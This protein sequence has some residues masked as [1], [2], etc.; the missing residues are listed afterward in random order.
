M[1]RRS[2]IFILCFALMA[3]LWAVSTAA[4][5]AAQHGYAPE[6]ELPSGEREAA[7]GFGLEIETVLGGRLV[8]RQDY[9]AGSGALSSSSRWSFREVPISHGR[10]YPVVGLDF[11]AG[12]AF[13]GSFDVEPEDAVSRRLADYLEEAWDGSEYF[14]TEI[15]LSDFAERY[16]P[17]ISFGNITDRDGRGIRSPY[18]DK[19]SV[20]V[21]EGSYYRAVVFGGGEWYISPHSGSGRCSAASSSVFTPEGSLFFTADVT[22]SAGERADGSSLPGGGW[23]VWRIPCEAEDAEKLAGVDRWWLTESFHAVCDET[24]LE[25]VFLLPEG[26]GDFEILLS[27]DG[28]RLFVISAEGGALALR[29]LSAADGALMQSLTLFTAAE[30]GEMGVEPDFDEFPLRHYSRESCEIF[31]L[32]DRAAAAVEL[33]GGEYALAAAF[34]VP[35]PEGWGAGDSLAGLACSGGRMAALYSNGY[36]RLDMSVF[37]GG[38]ELF[39]ETVFHPLLEAAGFATGLYCFYDITADSE[40]RS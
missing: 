4:L 30:L 3:G 37:D 10:S 2:Y 28:T 5:A 20:E 40:V 27:Y 23:G 15:D 36:G 24:A 14:E 39:R 34:A 32:G 22:N 21:P 9:D 26:C 33:S 7:E 13:G 8:W 25:N 12:F 38:G 16:D 31:T 29:V 11:T 1:F 17:E 35:V 18:G 19:F 6:A